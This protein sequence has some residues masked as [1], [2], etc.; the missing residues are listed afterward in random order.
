LSEDYAQRAR[1]QAWRGLAAL[2]GQLLFFLIP[3]AAVEFGYSDSTEIDFRALGLSAVTCAVALPLATLIA[4]VFVP[5]GIAAP[6]PK[7]AR[8][9]GLTAMFKAIRQN[10]PLLRLLAAFLPVNLLGGLSGGVIYLYV[11][12]YLGLGRHFA[13]IMLLAMVAGII[14]IPLWGALAARFERHRVWA[15]SLVAGALA[16]G[17]LT[18][19][20]PGPMA[21]PLVMI[22]Y[23]VIVLALTGSIVVFAMSADIVDYGRL[24]T[25]EDHAG[26]YGS[27]FAFLQKSLLGVSAAAGLALVGLFGFDATATTQTASGIIGI[28]FTSALLPAFGLL[29]AA[30]LIWNYP[31]TRA[32][33][34][35][36]QAQLHRQS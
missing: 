10:P 15:M 8:R 9:T 19:L 33:V 28:K 13:A 14:G 18:L 26:L 25:G 30:A 16:A 6:P 34:A 4:V 1:V 29:G 31:L 35:E 36:I 27:I 12:T 5:D 24:V 17:T 2:S 22:A 11:D 20:S 7:T 21:L 23:T 3:F 32:R